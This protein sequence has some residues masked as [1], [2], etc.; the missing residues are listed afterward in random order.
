MATT[1]LHHIKAYLYDNVLTIEDPN[2]FIARVSSER[3]L[4]VKQICELAV[5]RGGADISAPAMEHGVDRFL[6]EMAYQLCDGFSVNIGWFTVSVHIKG[7]FNSPNDHFDPKR[8]TIL[9]EF[10]Q[11]TLLRNKLPE[12]TVD[13]LGVAEVG[14]QILQVLD[15]KTGSVNDLLTP[16]RNLKISGHKIK[17]AGDNPEVGILFRSIEDPESVYRVDPTDIV[18]NNPSE[19][20][21]IIPQLIADT[22]KLEVT[23]QFTNSMLLKE[24]RSAVFDKTLTVQ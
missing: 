12:V 16:D 18:T 23:T 5:A 19:L 22:Y 17:I 2:D 3:S 4:N 24:P 8:H 7:V 13:I 21:I 10:H 20:V 14:L 1:I 6:T 15:V 9:F 11:G